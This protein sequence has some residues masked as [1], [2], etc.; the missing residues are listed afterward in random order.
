MLSVLVRRSPSVRRLRPLRFAIF[1]LPIT[2]AV[3]QDATKVAPSIASPVWK[4]DHA[5]HLIGLIESKSNVDGILSISPKMIAFTAPSGQTII[6]RARIFAISTGD[7][8]MEKGGT[9]G[10]FG[11]K[12][13]PYGGGSVIAAVTH[14]QVDLLTVEFRD[15]H[16]AYHGAVFLLPKSEALN[17]ATLF[18]SPIA[19]TKVE[20]PRPP[21]VEGPVEMGTH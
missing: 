17:A 16:D 1:L 21:C 13:I 6:E 10:R 2:S 12:V 20:T 15:A 3:C 11:R 5:R 14:K 8:R 19:Q 7:L 9:M 4:S 18:G